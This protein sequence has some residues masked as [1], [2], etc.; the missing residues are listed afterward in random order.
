MNEALRYWGPGRDNK[1]QKNDDT[2]FLNRR[3]NFPAQSLRR[4]SQSIQ[5][6]LKTL[7]SHD[8]APFLY[9]TTIVRRSF[10]SR[11]GA[12]AQKSLRSLDWSYWDRGR[13][14][15]KDLL[16]SSPHACQRADNEVFCIESNHYY[17]DMCRMALAIWIRSHMLLDEIIAWVNKY[18]VIAQRDW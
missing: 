1:T 9:F 2:Q 6:I 4:C 10:G 16:E 5:Y 12:E 14:G 18:E 8:V 15:E 13:V 7:Q 11:S 3:I 17:N